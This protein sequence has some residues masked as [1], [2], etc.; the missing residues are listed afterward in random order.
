MILFFWYTSTD[1]SG[2]Y[3]ARFAVDKMHSVFLNEFGGQK[4][5]HPRYHE[6]SFV[7]HVFGGC[8][9]SQVACTAL[10]HYNN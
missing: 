4:A 1:L 9:Q 3:T 6:T 5:A 10:I 8:F 2:I 7:Q